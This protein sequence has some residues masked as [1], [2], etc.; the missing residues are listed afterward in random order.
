[1]SEDT[2]EKW[3]EEEPFIPIPALLDA[4]ELLSELVRAWERDKRTPD[5]TGIAL[6]HLSDYRI[7]AQRAKQLLG[8]EK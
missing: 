6:L 4:W 7:I 1:M 3:P 5:R 8:E 2:P